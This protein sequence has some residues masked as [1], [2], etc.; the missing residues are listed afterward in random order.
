MAR[1][2]SRIFSVPWSA[3]ST[4]LT[5]MNATTRASRQTAMMASSATFSPD[6]NSTWALPSCASSHTRPI[7]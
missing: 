5:R 1:A 3:A 7:R 2:I 6:R 4:C